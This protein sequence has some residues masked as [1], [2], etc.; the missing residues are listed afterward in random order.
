MTG[1]FRHTGQ[2]GKKYQIGRPNENGRERIEDHECIPS[3]IGEQARNPHR[4]PETSCT[5]VHP[6]ELPSGRANSSAIALAETP[7]DWRRKRLPPFRLPAHLRIGRFSS[8]CPAL[9]FRGPWFCVVAKGFRHTSAT[10]HLLSTSHQEVTVRLP[11]K[12]RAS[13][14]LVYGREARRLRHAA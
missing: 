13:I 3:L 10:R 14:S 2:D 5:N 9:N 4:W 11:C 12:R 8:T 6:D 7:S 1:E